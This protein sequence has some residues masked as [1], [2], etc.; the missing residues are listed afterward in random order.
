MKA[1]VSSNGKKDKERKTLYLYSVYIF[2]GNTEQ[3]KR[4]K[5]KK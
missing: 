1:D 3:N 4:S 5:F 2:I